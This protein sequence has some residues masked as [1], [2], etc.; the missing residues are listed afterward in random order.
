MTVLLDTNVII[1]VLNDRGGRRQFFGKLVN[2][3]H[4]LACCASTVAEVYAGMRPKEAL[5]T[6]E[7]LSTLRYFEASRD[8]ARRAG[9]LKFAWARKGFTL[10][11]TDVLIA[12]VA[13]DHGL[14]LATGNQKHFPMPELELLAVPALD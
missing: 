12:A 10:G 4:D 6:E 13:L 3:G 5:A 9:L 14:K 8:A 7:F 2:E 1:D 11:L